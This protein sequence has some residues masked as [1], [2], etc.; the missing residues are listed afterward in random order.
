MGEGRGEGVE[1]L[2]SSGSW[3]PL[4]PA[5]SPLGGERGLLGRQAV[6]SNGRPPSW[7]SRR[8]SQRGTASAAA[9]AT[10]PAVPARALGLSRFGGGARRVG[11]IAGVPSHARLR[12]LDA[13]E[14]RMPSTVVVTSTLDTKGREVG[15]V[16]HR[17]REGGLRTLVVDTGVLGD[18]LDIVPDIDHDTVARA[19]GAT[20][21]RVRTI[22]AR[23]A[24]IEI[25]RE[26]LRHVLG[27]LHRHGRCDG[28]IALGGAEG[29]V[30]AAYAMQVLPI[31]VPKL[32]VT[33]VAAGRRPFGPFIGTRDI[34]VM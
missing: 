16:V 3:P 1:S 11:R 32:I 15:Y 30:M 14:G 5:L 23:G 2:E 4:T 18:P 27:D 31:G 29:A 7:G 20:L 25:M 22:G 34:L 8:P 9:I 28:V 33:P 17:L 10:A 19:G 13:G 21:E 26:G 24:A 6:V 12:Q